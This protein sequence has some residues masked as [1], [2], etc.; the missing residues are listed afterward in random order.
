[1]GLWLTPAELV[2]RTGKKQKRKQCEELARQG[3]R[4]TVRCDGFPLVDRSQFESGERLT[5]NQ[6]RRE[7][8]FTA[9]GR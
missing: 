8:R 3:V 6:R 5:I 4:F 9:I 2:E 1:M 7:P